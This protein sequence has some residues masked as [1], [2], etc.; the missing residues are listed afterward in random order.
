MWTARSTGVNSPK[1][2]W[3]HI[4]DPTI[5][6]TFRGGLRRM[7]SPH[8]FSSVCTH[9]VYPR[10]TEGPPTQ[11]TSN[12]VK[13]KK[14]QTGWMDYTPSDLYVVHCNLNYM[15]RVRVNVSCRCLC[16]QFPTIELLTAT[17]PHSLNNSHNLKG[18]LVRRNQTRCWKWLVHI[19]HHPY[20]LVN[21]AF[22]AI[23]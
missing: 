10:L 5:Q 2:H 3:G 22:N 4:W 16:A 20:C 14:P 21:S 19:L 12:D 1:M 9:T 23:H 6:T 18:C 8:S 7:M 11:P 13:K 15:F 17:S